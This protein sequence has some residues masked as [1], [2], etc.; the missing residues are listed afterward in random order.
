MNPKINFLL[1]LFGAIY[2]GTIILLLVGMLFGIKYTLWAVAVLLAIL[3]LS[4]LAIFAGPS[5]N[6]K[7]TFAKCHPPRRMYEIY[8]SRDGYCPFKEIPKWF[9]LAVMCGEDHK[10][11]KHKG[12]NYDAIFNALAHNV[13]SKGKLIGGSTIT[14]QLVKNIYL[15]PEITLKRKISELLIVRRV[16]RDLSKNEIMELY[17]NVI[18]YGFGKYGISSAAEFYYHCKP[19]DLSF[20]QCLSLAAILPCPDKYNEQANPRYFYEVRQKLL[21]KILYFSNMTFDQLV[22]LY[23]KGQVSADSNGIGSAQ[24]K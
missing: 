8:S 18:Y 17:A 12:L 9:I 5:V 15:T 2:I 14:Q 23:T 22:G 20:D 24:N 10:F 4:F 13:T 7:K 6:V 19:C 11:Y 1:Y 16:E 3:I 21:R